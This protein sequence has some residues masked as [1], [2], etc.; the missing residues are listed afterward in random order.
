MAHDPNEGWKPPVPPPIITNHEDLARPWH[1][2]ED[3]VVNLLLVS[4][5]KDPE[6][7]W[8]S[9]LAIAAIVLGPFAAIPGAALAIR[10]FRRI[11]VPQT[12]Q[13]R[14]DRMHARI[15]LIAAIVFGTLW[16]ILAGCI[17]FASR[18]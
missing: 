8:A 17:A 7:R 15:A 1:Q 12:K 16:L 18:L 10:A 6:V 9:G 5:V 13:Q 14:I 4:T 11:G 2:D 3:M